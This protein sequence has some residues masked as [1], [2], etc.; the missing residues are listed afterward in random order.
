M[1]CKDD[2]KTTLSADLLRYLHRKL[3]LPDLVYLEPPTLVAEGT[4]ALILGFRLRDA[5]EEYNCPLVLRILRTKGEPM[6]VDLEH[7]IQNAVADQGFPAPRVLMSSQAGDE[8]GQPFLI[9][10]RVAND[11]PIAG[12]MPVKR[13]IAAARRVLQLSH[14]IQNPLEIQMEAL[15]RLHSL[16]PIP[17]EKALK[18]R[19]ISPNRLSAERRIADIFSWIE[20]WKLDRFRPLAEW[21]QTRHP[22]PG[23]ISICHGDPHPMNMLI[24]KGKL[25]GMIDWE[26]AQLGHPALDV[27]A[28][29]GHIRTLQPFPLA[30]GSWTSHWQQRL[31]DRHIAAYERHRRI[32]RKA[33]RYYETEFLGRVIVYIA[34]RRIR[35]T[36]GETVA[37]NPLMDS[38]R[39]VRLIQMHLEATTGIEIPLSE[40]I[41]N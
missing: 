25:A 29:C 10:V 30:S 28:F 38:P 9:M 21:L 31:V 1:R 33:V 5:P 3:G 13:S 12:L 6:Q 16:D 17:L 23:Q 39:A 7:A 24:Y 26:E 19:G 20:T 41:I 37:G 34:M 14:V 35:R 18:D 4:E 15:A 11:L 27:G 32:D 8:L 2:V 22:A 40:D 36:E